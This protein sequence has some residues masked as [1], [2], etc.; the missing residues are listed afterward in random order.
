MLAATQPKTLVI[1]ATKQTVLPQKMKHVKITVQS[2]T[3]SYVSLLRDLKKTASDRKFFSA[4][5]GWC[6]KCV[7]L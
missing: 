2:T 5:P 4:F 1:H 6:E 3:V 7:I